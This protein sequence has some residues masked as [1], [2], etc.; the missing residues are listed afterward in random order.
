MNSIITAIIIVIVIG[1]VASVVII[2][3]PLGGS[4]KTGPIGYTNVLTGNLAPIYRAGSTSTT[5]AMVY[6]NVT[7]SN[8]STLSMSGMNIYLN[9]TQMFHYSGNYYIHY[10][11]GNGI[12]GI[13]EVGNFWSSSQTNNSDAYVVLF[14]S[15]P[16]GG[17]IQNGVQMDVVY[18]EI[19]FVGN[20]LLLKPSYFNVMSWIGTGLT[21]SH[22]GYMDN[23]T[24]MIGDTN[25]VYG[26]HLTISYN[27]A[28]NNNTAELNLSLV[29]FDP[30][31]LPV[32]FN[33][34]ILDLNN[35][36]MLAEFNIITLSN[37]SA[38]VYQGNITSANIYFN[39]KN[40]TVFGN[41]DSFI[42]LLKFIGPVNPYYAGSNIGFEIS[43][44]GKQITLLSLVPP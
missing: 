14:P 20:A 6:M 21:I 26:L 5:L 41:G 38:D 13:L 10:P 24:G 2:V 15:L 1:A 17:E 32:P 27:T 33:I 3:N 25:Y 29:K 7:M 16:V 30:G 43:Y 39:S 36:T 31:Y 18:A 35:N 4:G 11:K 42:I 19:S 22:T 9:E 40:D 28:F 34:T 8:P 44:K 12:S 23:I 37:K